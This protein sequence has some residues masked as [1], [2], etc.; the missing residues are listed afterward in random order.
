MP[1]NI[2][3]T[4]L[5]IFLL[6]AFVATVAKIWVNYTCSFRIDKI[7]PGSFF[8][9]H[10]DIRISK[11]SKLD[12]I[13][14]Q[15]F[16]FLCKG[17]HTFVFISENNKYVIKFFRFH[18]Y[19]LPINLQ[20]GKS[21]PFISSICEKLEKELDILYLETM[22]SYRLVYEKIKNETATVYVHLN[23]TSDLN[24]KFRIIDKFNISYVIN[25]NDFGFVIQKKAKT[26]SKKLLECKNDTRIVEDLLTS[27]FI[28]LRSIYK[29]G[30]LNKDRHVLNNLG[31]IDNKVV[32][33]DVGRFAF[34]KE[35]SKKDIL[36]KEAYQYT[37]Y[38][39]KWLSKNI[40]EALPFLD[41]QLIKLI[42]SE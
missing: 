9:N 21:L 31:I 37:T 26:F 29:K 20:I 12:S 18:R 32:E 27:F 25:L 39:R 38:L 23:K 17:R 40:P 42:E 11:D 10:I 15:K 16:K 24:K 13:L 19:R 28:N 8:E 30:I 22:D 2:T 36:E 14:N 35:L 5:K 3:K 4:G 7:N 6:V 41:S 34:Y 33:I 1:Y